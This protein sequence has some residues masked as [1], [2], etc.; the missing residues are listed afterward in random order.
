MDAEPKEARSP[1]LWR[2][3]ASEL[4]RSL[5]WRFTVFGNLT[6]GL[7][8]IALIVVLTRHTADIIE[9]SGARH[10]QYL[11]ASRI[12]NFSSDMR[13]LQVIPDSYVS[14]V[15]TGK[16][17]DPDFF[18]TVA[19]HLFADLRNSVSL[20]VELE[21]G[22]FP[23]GSRHYLMRRDPSSPGGVRVDIWDAPEETPALVDKAWFGRMK[24]KWLASQGELASKGSRKVD[25]GWFSI[26]PSA[27]PGTGDDIVSYTRPIVV[28]GSDGQPVLAGGA[29]MFMHMQYSLPD[30]GNLSP[31][32]NG[33]A[34]LAEKGHILAEA[35][36]KPE[37]KDAGGAPAF[38]GGNRIA[39]ETILDGHFN[40]VSANPISEG[41]RLLTRARDP[42]GGGETLILSA[43]VSPTDW[44]LFFL[45]PQ[46]EL[47]RE[48]RELAWYMLCL[49]FLGFLSTTV[50]LGYVA[51]KVT[52]NLKIIRGGVQE[53]A[54]GRLDVLL[55]TPKANDE[56]SDLALAFNDMVRCLGEHIE[57]LKRVT[58]EKERGEAEIVLAQR[59]QLSLL[60]GELASEHLLADGLT[61]PA[62]EVGGDL[63]DYFIL[64]EGRIGFAVGDVTGKGLSAGLFMVMT[65]TLLRSL[66]SRGE[67]G[68]ALARVNQGLA[69]RNKEMMLVTFLYGVFDP[70]QSVLLLVNA[71][72]PPPA[73]L[74]PQGVRYRPCPPSFP[75]GFMEEQVF[76]QER[77]P[78][79]PG[80]IVVLYTDGVTEAQNHAEE[81]FG[82]D[83]LLKVLE[84][85]SEPS[86][87]EACVA[88]K[89]AALL[90]QHGCEQFD[91]ITVM[92][93]APRLEVRSVT[94]PADLA[95][96]SDVEKFVEVWA[97]EAG[98]GHKQTHDILLAVMETATNIIVHA[99]RQ[100]PAQTFDLYAWKG[101]GYLSFRL[102]D[103][104]PAFNPDSV[105]T[106]SKERDMD[107]WAAGGMG[108]ALI[109]A[110]MDIVVMDR[111]GERN[112]LTI[113]KLIGTGSGD[114]ESS[115]IDSEKSA[116]SG[117]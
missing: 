13:A 111:D 78:V 39:W 68:Q 25:P 92:A 60:P 37:K 96:L 33:Y 80:E 56:V 4:S 54:K 3:L 112:V 19:R 84:G 53:L 90:W 5:F 50:M 66:A 75:L 99:L 47:I 7:I 85:L 16:G 51:G 115:K 34:V 71:G 95:R 28:V 62:R 42:V 106:V 14:I 65:S 76:I 52:V 113:C 67:P 38:S 20:S 11:L 101:N 29:A 114:E 73:I 116:D 44:R 69:M 93:I 107:E 59:M 89:D 49:A 108:W 74:G 46:N 79:F 23:N 98:C 1:G 8:I 26:L 57:E 43:P 40:E 18:R 100:D 70:V 22:F 77:V 94:L 86:T 55:P 88:L 72:H 17:L 45:I 10:M 58:K 6:A 110:R 87:S 35:S 15:T 32:Q 83:R 81:L 48:I 21:D 2:R 97:S 117:D 103:G 30:F 61:L 9:A 63:F 27:N 41:G 105:K 82:N 12:H 91:D 36:F 109:R 64:P 102:V 104:G 31:Y 24:E